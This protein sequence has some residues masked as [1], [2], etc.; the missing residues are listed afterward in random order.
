MTELYDLSEIRVFVS[1]Q[2][3]L[4]SVVG[5]VHIPGVCVLVM[6]QCRDETGE[7]QDLIKPLVAS[8]VHTP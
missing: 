6:W 1:D 5:T 2:P 4:Y 8:E 7:N 3:I